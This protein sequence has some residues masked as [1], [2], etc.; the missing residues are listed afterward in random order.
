MEKGKKKHLRN[1]P[2]L[3]DSFR[4]ISSSMNNRNFTIFVIKAVYPF[5]ILFDLLIIHVADHGSYFRHMILLPSIS[6]PKKTKTKG[7]H[8]R[9][10]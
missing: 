5:E 1:S 7:N 2:Q 6:N 4:G 10:C 8:L 3:S 9:T